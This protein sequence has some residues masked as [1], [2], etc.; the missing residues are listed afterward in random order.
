MHR[1]NE[2]M[3][4]HFYDIKG[5]T[6]LTS[7]GGSELEKLMTEIQNQKGRITEQSTDFFYFST[8]LSELTKLLLVIQSHSPGLLAPVSQ[9]IIRATKKPDESLI[10]YGL[11]L[12]RIRNICILISLTSFI[13]FALTVKFLSL[14]VIPLALLI[15]WCW[16]YP[17]A[18]ISVRDSFESF[19]KKR[20]HVNEIQRGPV[21]NIHESKGSC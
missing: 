19:L 2:F 4:K 7:P 13:S 18:F 10:E 21:I 3:K 15:A 6:K 20:Y 9:G 8:D 1:H 16:I 5:K 17:M 11:S 14:V 12:R